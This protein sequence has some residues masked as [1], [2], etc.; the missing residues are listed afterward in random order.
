MTVD[1]RIQRRL[2]DIRVALIGKQAESEAPV[3]AYCERL[4]RLVSAVLT[5]THV[6]RA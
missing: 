6:G 4:N 5:E 1:E 2:A 3:A